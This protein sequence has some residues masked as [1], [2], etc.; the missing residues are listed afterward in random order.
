MIIYLQINQENTYT[1]SNRQIKKMLATKCAYIS[2][3]VY[4]CIVYMKKNFKISWKDTKKYLNKR[5]DILFSWEIRLNI[6]EMSVLP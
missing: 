6:M 3:L 1:P 4:M 2:I 5:D